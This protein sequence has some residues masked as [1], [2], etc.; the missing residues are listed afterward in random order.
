MRAVRDGSLGVEEDD[1]DA[2]RRGDAGAAVVLRGAAGSGETPDDQLIRRA[3]G[4]DGL[5]RDPVAGDDRVLADRGVVRDV[6]DV[7]AD[8]RSDVRPVGA[9]GEAGGLGGRLSRVLGAQ[10]DLAA[11]RRHVRAGADLRLVLRDDP[12][13]AHRGRDADAAAVRVATLRAGRAV[14]LIGAALCRRQRA[15]VGVARGVRVVGDFALCPLVR[16]LLAAAATVVVFLGA[17]RRRVSVR[18][19]VRGGLGADLDR[20]T[21]D[22]AVDFSQ[23]VPVEDDVEGD[24]DAD[25]GAAFGDGLRLGREVAVVLGLD[26]DLPARGES[27]RGGAEPRDGVLAVEDDERDTRRDARVLA[28]RAHVD[29]GLGLATR[30]RLDV[31]VLAAGD[32][33]AILGLRLRLGGREDVQRHR[34]SDACALRVL[35]LAVCLGHVELVRLRLDRDVVARRRDGAAGERVG[36]GRDDVDLDS[37]RDAVW[38]AVKSVVTSL[39][40]RRAARRYAGT[41]PP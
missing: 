30:A 27:A 5:D 25:G 1:F 31:D 24:A 35:G 18:L 7:D 39:E 17:L 3:A 23:R 11:R 16:A 22:V 26:G 2:D 33:G 20:R 12:V 4:I 6:V 13:E 28:G 40:K 38:G 15:R 41:D 14:A 36:L 34:G 29:F 8:G 9:G 32:G 19:G 10:L 21:R 37:A